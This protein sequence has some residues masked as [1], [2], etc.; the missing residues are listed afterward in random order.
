LNRIILFE[1]VSGSHLYGTNTETSDEDY[2]GVF[3]PS[4]EDLL[5]LENCPQEW[6][7]NQKLSEGP[8]NEKGDTDRKFFSL[9]SFCN[10]AAQGQAAIL[11]MLF[12]PPD[13]IIQKHP[14][15]QKVEDNKHLFLSR[16]GVAPFLG[17]ARSQAHKA[18]IKGENLNLIKSL[19]EKLENVDRGVKLSEHFTN[20]QKDSVELLGHKL[21]LHVNE[22]GFT[23]LQLAGKDTDINLKTKTFHNNLKE[24]LE[25]YGSRTSN[26][27][28]DGYDYK[29]VLHAVRQLGEAEEFL[30]TGKITLP[31]PPEELELLMAIRRKEWPTAD[32][33]FF[34]YMDQRIQHIQTVVDEQSPLPKEPN[35]TKINEL[36]IEIHKSVL[37]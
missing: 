31:R 30:K 32:V 25:R 12:A 7:L 21:R 36:C 1:C 10:F 16:R 5:G 35:R 23:Q 27:A 9:K 18:V 11:E 17:F 4:V 14:L 13:K 19:I 2:L 26:A 15:W 37:I 6:K 34:G 28:K 3:L 22:H 8:R 33:D 24:L 29:S 20:I